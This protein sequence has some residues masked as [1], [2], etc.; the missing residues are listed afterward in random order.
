M[1][2]EQL[3]ELRQRNA[4]RA[5]AAREALGTRWLRHPANRV[6][7]KPVYLGDMGVRMPAAT[8]HPTPKE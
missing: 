8:S 1:T 4:R 3:N 7:R 6:K 5:K 2:N